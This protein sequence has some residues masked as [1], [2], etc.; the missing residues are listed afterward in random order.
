METGRY[1]IRSIPNLSIQH[2]ERWEGLKS[3]NATGGLHGRMFLV[4]FLCSLFLFLVSC[5][6]FFGFC[7]WFFV[8]F[9]AFCCFL[10]LLSYHLKTQRHH[11]TELHRYSSIFPKL[12]RRADSILHQIQY[13]KHGPSALRRPE[14]TETV[15]LVLCPHLSVKISFIPFV[16]R[17]VAMVSLFPSLP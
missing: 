16:R 12:G 3:S 10:F 13:R 15:A 11:Q 7:F 1:E 4:L 14:V 5:S 2:S 9:V 17:D 6:N 8:F